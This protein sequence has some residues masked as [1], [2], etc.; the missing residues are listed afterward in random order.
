MGQDVLDRPLDEGTP[1]QAK[2]LS[3]WILLVDL[4]KGF[5]DEAGEWGRAEEEESV[6]QSVNQSFSQSVSQSVTQTLSQSEKADFPVRLQ[7]DK[8][9]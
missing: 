4:A 5:E 3:V 6:G 1:D 8:P 9:S 7:T 2:A